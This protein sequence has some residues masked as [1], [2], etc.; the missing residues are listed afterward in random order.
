[1]S[2]VY[3]PT[4]ASAAELQ[5]KAAELRRMADTATTED[6]R[7]A[8]IRLAARLNQLAEARVSNSSVR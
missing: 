2:R 3:Q 5:A 6:T 8:L 1:M 7:E 4:D